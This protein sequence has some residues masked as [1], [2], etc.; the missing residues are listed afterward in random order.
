MEVEATRKPPDT[1]WGRKTT[2]C[3]VLKM[4]KGW[5]VANKKNMGQGTMIYYVLIE[6]DLFMINLSYIGCYTNCNSIYNCEGPQHA[7]TVII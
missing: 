3:A 7:I 2:S 1:S 6:N 5:L 4:R